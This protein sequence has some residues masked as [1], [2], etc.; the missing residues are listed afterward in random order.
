MFKVGGHYF[1]FYIFG[2][3][4]NIKKEAGLDP[5]TEGIIQGT[6]F[7]SYHVTFLSLF[8]EL[9]WFA[10]LL[11]YSV[12]YHKFRSTSNN[13]LWFHYQM[14]QFI[15]YYIYLIAAS[16]KLWTHKLP[17]NPSIIILITVTP[18]VD[19]LWP[20]LRGGHPLWV[21]LVKNNRLV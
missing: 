13:I 3:F 4:L 18:F 6:F 7:V 16:Y 19:V 8:V 12:K 11:T 14:Q 5:V 2:D 20:L 9:R 17:W 1:T 21:Y 15:L 10:L